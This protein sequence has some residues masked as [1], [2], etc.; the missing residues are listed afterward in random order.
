MK[1]PLKKI[2]VVKPTLLK[3]FRCKKLKPCSAFAKANYKK[4][5]FQYKCRKCDGAIKGQWVLKNRIRYNKKHLELYYKNP[6][7]QSARS[8]VNYEI[9]MGRLFRKPCEVCGEK[10]VHAHHSDY[11]KPLLINWLCITHHRQIHHG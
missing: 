10:R 6:E 3:C 7:K 4:R 9:S 5:G 2:R 8:K 1:S 11:R